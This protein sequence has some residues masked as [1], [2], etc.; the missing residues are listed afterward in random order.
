MIEI[1]PKS[2]W[3]FEVAL[4]HSITVKVIEG[5]AEIF[6]TELSNDIEYTFSSTKRAIYSLDG[7]KLE[8]TG[9][10][11]S[12]YISEETQM[13]SYINLFLALNNYRQTTGKAPR[14]LI[15]GGKDSGK[16]SLSK[17]LV[18]YSSRIGF[19]PMLVNLNPQEGVFSVP[20]T[21]TA[22]P[23]S[24]ILDVEDI[25]GWGQ[26]YTSGPTLFHPKQ[27]N[28]R[29]YGYDKIDDNLKFYKYNVS[30]LGVT[31]CS[32][33]EE[34]ENLKKSGLIIDTPALS[35]K[36]IQLI[37]DIISDFEVNIIVVI[38]N[39][40][41]FIDVKKKLNRDSLNIVKL[42]KSGG[43]VEK[44]D[45]FIRNVQQKLIKEYFYGNSKLILSPYTVNVDFTVVNVYQPFIESED[46]VSSV[47]P[48]GEIEDS[49]D[50]KQK[51][52]IEKVEINSSNLQNSVVAIL[53]ADKNEDND[54]IIRSSVLGFAVITGADDTKKKLRIL[55][56]VPGRL[57]DKIMVLGQ[58][59]YME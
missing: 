3:R 50:L 20:G 39:E 43:C 11:N 36:N 5:I 46:L 9:E 17:I 18:S 49:S 14:V 47:L 53:H 58:Y 15:I 54:E 26:S 45:V 34:D 56:P 42:P 55:I 32:R 30:R 25:L 2:E 52:L 44:D 41:L 33:L 35:Y 59:R 16:T 24:D 28:V 23:I 19:E 8:Y 51:N 13:D 48:V 29:Y 31:V 6:G 40:R 7:C 10:L 12:E 22:T 38:G 4:D 57:P 37:E 21:I 1:A 27:P